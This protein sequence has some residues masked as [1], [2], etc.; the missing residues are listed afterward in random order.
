MG[1]FGE[2]Q[3]TAGGA[4]VMG[5]HHQGGSAVYGDSPSG[6][7]IHGKGG[8][9]AGF[10]EGDVEVTGDIRLANADCAEDFDHLRN[11]AD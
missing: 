7:G 1:V 10:F 5:Y 4:G 8:R 6:I 11:G 3:S 2:T 9:L